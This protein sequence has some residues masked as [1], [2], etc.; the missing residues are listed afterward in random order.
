MDN[1]NTD[2]EQQNVNAKGFK[3]E[4]IINPSGYHRDRATN[5]IYRIEDKVIVKKKSIGFIPPLPTFT[6]LVKMFKVN[7]PSPAGGWYLVK[8]QR[9]WLKKFLLEIVDDLYKNEGKRE[10]DILEAGIASFNHHFSYLL[11]LKEV[12]D[13]LGYKDLILNLTVTD[14]AYYPLF[15]IDRINKLTID[16][17]YN[18]RELTVFN[19][20]IPLADSF[21]T[22]I[23]ESEIL[24]F[25]QI[26]TKTKQYDLTDSE[27]AFNLGRFDIITE[28]FITAVIDNFQIIKLIRKTYSKILRENGY[29]LNASGI[30]PHIHDKQFDEFLD[31]HEELGLMQKERI[32]VWDPYGM[33]TKD[34]LKIL[35]GETIE[36]P[37]DNS[38]FVFKK[39]I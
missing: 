1:K 13:E 3:E 7:I 27:S 33:R 32:N 8:E 17:L 15:C 16:K 20:K 22:F 29:I 25:N 5:T 28:H 36:T 9:D 6:E 39:T 2:Q 34:L 38:L 21:L 23:R 18:K 37:F 4:L 35:K 10:I 14:S 30:T 31:I 12:I 19:N 24:F 11:I 26:N